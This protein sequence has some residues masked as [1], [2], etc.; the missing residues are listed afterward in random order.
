MFERVALARR[1]DQAGEGGQMLRRERLPA[2]GD[3]GGRPRAADVGAPGRR[4]GDHRGAGCREH[5]GLPL[6]QVED[7]PVEVVD[8]QSGQAF[9]RPP[10]DEIARLFE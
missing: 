1:F 2:G 5:R 6:G 4:G 8:A 7:G 9:L 10:R 3:P